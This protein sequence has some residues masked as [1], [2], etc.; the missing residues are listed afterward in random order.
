M[1]IHFSE[2]RLEKSG[3]IT[4]NFG[5]VREFNVI[6]YFTVVFK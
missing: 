6:Y 2:K 1:G 4:E 5:K 3:K